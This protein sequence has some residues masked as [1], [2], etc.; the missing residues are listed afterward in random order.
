[1]RLVSRTHR[2]A[3]NW[4]FDRINFDPKVQIKCVE[5]KNQIAD[6]LTKGS[7]TR[8][9]WHNLLHLLSIMNDT[10]FS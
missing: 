3:L 10:T 5:S 9:D 7:F 4:L 2:V 6:I 8:D 1:M